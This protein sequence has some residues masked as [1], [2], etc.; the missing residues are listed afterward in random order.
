MYHSLLTYSPNEGHLRYFKLLT[1]MNKATINIH[2][3]V[4]LFGHNKF[5]N[6]LGKI[7]RNMIV[8]SYGKTI[9]TLVRNHQTLFTSGCTALR[10]HQQWSEFM[11][12]HITTS[13]WDYQ[14][15]PFL[16]LWRLCSALFMSQSLQQPHE[17]DFMISILQMRTPRLWEVK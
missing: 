14:I 10:C 15:S 3:Q 2:V 12:L 9:F 8:E 13:I 16:L 6:L 4:F 11:L 1:I 17:M 7:P 5:S